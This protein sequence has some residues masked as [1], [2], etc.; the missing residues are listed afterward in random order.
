MFNANKKSRV[1]FVTPGPRE[2]QGWYAGSQ[3]QTIDQQAAQTL[4]AEAADIL[5]FQVLVQ[6]AG[7]GFLSRLLGRR[8]YLFPRCT[9]Y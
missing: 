2:W 7:H 1:S 5:A 3:T 8:C 9:P 4:A 6:R